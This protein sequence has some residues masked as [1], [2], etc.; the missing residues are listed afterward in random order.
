MKMNENDTQI[1]EEKLK[2]FYKLYSDLR[3]GQGNS[4]IPFST[5][6]LPKISPSLN[7]SHEQIFSLTSCPIFVLNISTD[8]NGDFS[9]IVVLKNGKYFLTIL[10]YDQFLCN[11]LELDTTEE[12]SELFYLLR[13]TETGL[14]EQ[15]EV[16]INMIIEY[17]YLRK[18]KQL[19][20]CVKCKRVYCRETKHKVCDVCK[21]ADFELY[22]PLQDSN[23][24]LS[25]QR[26]WREEHV[27]TLETS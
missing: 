27:P 20:R 21:T 11:E 13:D 6:L 16:L 25:F 2:E 15:N 9:I 24:L 1:T 23:N 5:C 4:L 14:Y 26:K 10:L 19:Y 3:D 22:N 7:Y 18:A 8:R 12:V 17:L